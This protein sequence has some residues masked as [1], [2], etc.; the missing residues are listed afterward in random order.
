VQ[1]EVPENLRP[2]IYFEDQ[3]KKE[4]FAEYRPY[5]ERIKKLVVGTGGAT[6]NF[7]DH[8]QVLNFNNDIQHKVRDANLATVNIN[9]LDGWKSDVYPILVVD[10]DGMNPE[11][12]F[13]VIE[14]TIYGHKKPNIELARGYKF[15]THFKSGNAVGEFAVIIQCQNL[16]TCKFDGFENGITLRTDEV[17][18][19]FLGIRKVTRN[20]YG[21]SFHLGPIKGELYSE[22]SKFP[23]SLVAKQSQTLTDPKEFNAILE[24]FF[25]IHTSS[26]YL[27]KPRGDLYRKVV[28][29]PDPDSSKLVLHF[30]CF[31]LPKPP[32]EE[33]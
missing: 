4:K 11:T 24:S 30:R 29:I 17:K 6:P 13:Q 21:R 3:F 26:I 32:D 8:E 33:E 1:L 19:A 22:L 28:Q 12:I 16:E 10:S 14:E 23:P 9:N 20:R 7:R 5:I 25:E 27:D 15:L 2:T 18:P 31:T